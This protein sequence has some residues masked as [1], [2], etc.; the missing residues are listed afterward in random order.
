MEVGGPAEGAG[1][2]GRGQYRFGRD[3]VSRRVWSALC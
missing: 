2:D 3:S 1:C